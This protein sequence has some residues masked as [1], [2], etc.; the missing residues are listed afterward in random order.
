METIILPFEQWPLVEPI[1]TKEFRD[2]MPLTPAQ[3]DF[4]A[5]RDGQSVA[6]FLHVEHL[7]HF[8]S[9]YIMPEYRNQGLAMRLIRKATS[10]IPPLHSGIWLAP[11]DKGDSIESKARRLAID[12]GAREVGVYR[13]FR[14][15]VR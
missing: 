4:V 2:A 7:Y 10:S 8:N 1:V 5:L 15:D 12:M 9:L 14:K 3:S 6:G 13:V 11:A